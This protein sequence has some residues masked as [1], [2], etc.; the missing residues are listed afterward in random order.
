MPRRARFA[1]F[2]PACPVRPGMP[3]GARWCPPGIS[4]T[5]TSPHG[6]AAGNVVFLVCTSRNLPLRAL[7]GRS[8]RC[9][10]VFTAVLRQRAATT[11]SGNH[12][13]D[14]MANLFRNRGGRRSKAT[15]VPSDSEGFALAT[16]LTMYWCK[17]TDNTHPMF[18]DVVASETKHA[19]GTSQL[20]EKVEI[21]ELIQDKLWKKIPGARSHCLP[22]S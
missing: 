6:R 4:R 10:E 17:Q 5:T 8:A 9:S 13:R 18:Y 20:W 19:K 14:A 11:A 15:H 21:K 2:A 7:I 3:G 22:R 16:A 1:R 12:S